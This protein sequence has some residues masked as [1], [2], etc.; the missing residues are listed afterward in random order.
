MIDRANI[1]LSHDEAE[2]F[3]N[4]LLNPESE[5]VEARSAF[6]RDADL[7]TKSGAEGNETRVYSEYLNEDAIR[8][9]ILRRHSSRDSITSSKDINSEVAFTH[10]ERT[11]FPALKTREYN[12]LNAFRV[13]TKK[14]SFEEDRKINSGYPS[15]P[16]ESTANLAA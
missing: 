8:K 6:L 16:G 1:L 4:S 10:S 3:L 11:Y 2:L 7:K 14:E 12:F 15:F 13:Q 5:V 9:A